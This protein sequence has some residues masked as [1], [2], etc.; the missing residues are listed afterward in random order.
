MATTQGY[1]IAPAYAKGL[2][3]TAKNTPPRFEVIN[4]SDGSVAWTW[5]PPIAD[6]SF[7]GNVVLA[8]NLAF[9]STDKAVYAIDLVTR[10]SVWSY[11]MSGNLAIS[12]DFKLYIQNNVIPVRLVGISLR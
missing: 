3:Y 7:V 8:D 4:E 11:P 12:P 10:Q 5:V 6:T 1:S 2:I 9:I